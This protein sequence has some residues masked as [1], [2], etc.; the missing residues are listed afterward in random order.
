MTKSVGEYLVWGY[1]EPLLTVSNMI[2][3]SL[4]S[5][6]S[7]DKIGL[8]F[9]RNG[10]AMMEGVM[11]VDTGAEDLSKMGKIH[12]HNYDNQSHVFE[13]ECGRVMGSVGEFLGPMLS[14]EK[15]IDLYFADLCR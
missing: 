2:P 6:R 9:E 15:P 13:A 1:I 8:I 3:W 11:N 12:Y 4:T 7:S 10:S 14:R 5:E